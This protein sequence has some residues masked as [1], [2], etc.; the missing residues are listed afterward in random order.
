MHQNPIPAAAVLQTPLG[1]LR[2]LPRTLQLDLRGPTFKGRDRRGRKKTEGKGMGRECCE[3]QKILKIADGGIE[4]G[5]R[6]RL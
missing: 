4:T 1:E 3:V 5:E 6:W 2:A